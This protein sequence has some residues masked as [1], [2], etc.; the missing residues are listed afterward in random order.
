MAQENLILGL[1]ALMPIAALIGGLFV[2]KA[3][4]RMGGKL[5]TQF[6][7]LSLG[8]F[9]LALYGMLTSVQ[10]AGVT[11]FSYR[12]GAFGVVHILL[13]LCFTTTTLIGMINIRRLTGG[14]VE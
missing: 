1:R 9:F 5:G 13:H 3:S 7:I 12:D 6:K 10:D 2:Y 11:L 4:N 8:T 14:E